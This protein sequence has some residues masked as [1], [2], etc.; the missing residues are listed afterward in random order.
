MKDFWDNRYGKK[1]FAYGK[2]PNTFFKQKLGELTPG[3]LLLPAE[4]E[5]RNAIYAAQQHWQ[6]EACDISVEGKQ[7]AETL[8]TQEGVFIHYQVG[9]FGA[10]HYKKES[11]NAIA[12]I[13]A[14][15]PGSLVRAYHQ[16]VDGY[17]KSGGT[18]IFEAFSKNHLAYSAKNEKAGGP[19]NVEML[20]SVEELAKDFPNYNIK[21][22][23]EVEIDLSEGIYHLGKSSVI[24]FVGIKK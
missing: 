24:R 15:F 21:L 8:A 7:K 1:E 6:V 5:G 18:L 9:A 11:F 2:A 10:L 19:K 4:G 17:L 13:Y 23:E 16:L 22:L 20:F 3:Q 12:L 14:H